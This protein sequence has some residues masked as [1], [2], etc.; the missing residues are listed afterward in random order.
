MESQDINNFVQSVSED[1]PKALGFLGQWMAENVTRYY[2]FTS[3]C[4]Q[5]CE[6]A[7]DSVERFK[8]AGQKLH[9]Q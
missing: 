3:N 5:S 7:K 9:R 2:N 8:V 4:S 6:L 1:Q